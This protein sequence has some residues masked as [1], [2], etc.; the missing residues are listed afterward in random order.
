MT[1]Q[2][3][4]PQKHKPLEDLE[5]LRGHTAEEIFGY[6]ESHYAGDEDALDA[7]RRRREDVAKADPERGK[8][9]A[10]QAAGFVSYWCCPDRGGED[11]R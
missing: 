5:W 8:Q 3:D 4:I 6:I 1:R 7:V 10:M 9:L 11:E 2:R